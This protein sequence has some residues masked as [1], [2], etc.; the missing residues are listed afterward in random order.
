M[1]QSV[2]RIELSAVLFEARPGE[3][4]PSFDFGVDVGV[5]VDKAAQV[6]KTIRL[7]VLLVGS[8]DS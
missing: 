7:F 5:F 3:S 4:D 1:A 6:D 8:L 2:D